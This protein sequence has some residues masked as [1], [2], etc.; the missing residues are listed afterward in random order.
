MVAYLEDV[1][2]FLMSLVTATLLF[3][4]RF[5]RSSQREV[6]WFYVERSFSV[7]DSIRR[8]NVASS[9]M[10]NICHCLMRV[11]SDTCV[12]IILHSSLRSDL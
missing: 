9:G 11:T 3:S 6:V 4:T 10:S 2:K 8:W 5:L 7:T 1:E 12:E